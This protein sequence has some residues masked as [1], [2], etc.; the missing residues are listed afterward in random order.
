M[1]QSIRAARPRQLPAPEPTGAPKP[2]AASVKSSARAPSA[3]PAL[4]LQGRLRQALTEQ[5][6]GLQGRWS[7]RAT[8]G[9]CFGVSALLWAGV[10]LGLR[11][12]L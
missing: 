1:A 9:A 8:I 3:S 10:I 7:P 6:A 12:L 11:A 4:A 2:V 5:D